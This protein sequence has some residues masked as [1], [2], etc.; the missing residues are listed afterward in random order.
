M[1]LGCIIFFSCSNTK[2]LL[3]DEF[4]I[5]TDQEKLKG[6]SIVANSDCLICHKISESLIGPSYNDISLRYKPTAKTIDFLSQ[7]I[8]NGGNGSWGQVLMTPHNN[9]SDD[10]SIL[11]VKYI[12]SL[13]KINP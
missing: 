10:S 9:I 4:V 8:I 1:I 11:I 7:K 2:K 12:L 3:S 13:K 5:I 6:L